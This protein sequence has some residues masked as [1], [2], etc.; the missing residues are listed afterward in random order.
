[1]TA[2][3][4]LLLVSIAV[5][6]LAGSLGRQ[7]RQ[8][9]QEALALELRALSDAALAEALAELGRDRNFAG[10]PEHS[11]DR[12]AIAS[13]VEPLGPNLYFV[14]ASA[15]LGVRRRTI[16]AEVRR[17][18]EELRVSEWRRVPVAESGR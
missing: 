17:V 5:G 11:F 3:F 16:E 18:A 7:L 9:Q 10:L 8:L 6:L 2:L 4:V 13:E 1:M 14:R 12:G 15:R